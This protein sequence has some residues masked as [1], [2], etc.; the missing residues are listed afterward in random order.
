MDALRSLRPAIE[1]TGN[2]E[3]KDAYN[4]AIIALK[5]ARRSPRSTDGVSPAVAARETELR[6]RIQDTS[7][8]EQARLY[9]RRGVKLHSAV[10]EHNSTGQTTDA[11]EDWADAMNA[12]GRK[13]RETK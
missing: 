4:R 11:P 3:A 9:H 13:L 6:R 8:G 2:R 12:R 5:R 10:S 1:R 7:F